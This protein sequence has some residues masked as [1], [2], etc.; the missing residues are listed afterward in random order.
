MSSDD[1]SRHIRPFDAVML[2]VGEGHWIYVE[3]AGRKGAVPALFLH[4]GPGSGS[5]HLH[6][7]LFSAANNHAILFD[8][9]GAG[10]SHPYLNCNANTTRH[11]VS[12]I[13]LI[14]KFL[15][16]EKWIVTG[17]SWGST[18]ALAYAEAHPERVAAIVLRAV[19]LGTG[20][21]VQW[22]FIEGPKRFR[23]ELYKQFVMALPQVERAY[24]LTAYLDR[25]N[26]PDPNIY[27]PAAN[28][29]NAYERG[30]SVLEPSA[31][32]L[33]NLTEQPSRVPPSPLLE[34][35]YIV[36]NFFLEDDQLLAG[37]HR[38]KDIP[39]AIIQGRYDLLCPP[40]SAHALCEQWPACRLKILE[41]AG[42][43][44]TE[45]GVFASLRAE[46][47]RFTVNFEVSQNK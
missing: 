8:Q 17:G 31:V 46:I 34:A 13:E 23:P 4:G 33:P 36:N 15:R 44:L 24:P 3:E 7:E 25:L 28:V 35:H 30:L 6:R 26:N 5:Q 12:D 22:A 18:L 39:G 47:E 2:A 19:F 11:L 41:S 16:I 43:S 9:R 1:S 45:P 10:R 37:A 32:D 29:W 14:R 38:L 20:Q 40:S 42:H 27:G 21:E